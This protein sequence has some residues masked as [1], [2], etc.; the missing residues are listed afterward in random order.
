MS[1]TMTTAR[2]TQAGDTSVRLQQGVRSG[3]PVM[4]PGAWE[5][6]ARRPVVQSADPG[7]VRA[8][9]PAAI[10]DDRERLE[11]A[12]EGG[13]APSERPRIQP[14]TIFARMWHYILHPAHAIFV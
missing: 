6:R 5:A 9:A 8:T 7:A 13:G 3:L 1:E 14:P 11:R 4:I 10:G 2:R 12:R